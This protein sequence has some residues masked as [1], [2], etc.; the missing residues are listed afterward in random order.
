MK[1]GINLYNSRNKPVESYDALKR[2]TAQKY[3]YDDKYILASASNSMYS[4]FTHSSFE[5][6]LITGSS[7]KAVGGE[8]YI[9]ANGEIVNASSIVISGNALQAHSGNKFLKIPAGTTGLTYE[10]TIDPAYNPSSNP[11]SALNTYDKLIEEKDY[12]VYLWSHRQSTGQPDIEVYLTDAGGSNQSQLAHNATSILSTPS[13]QLFKLDFKIPHQS[14]VK[15]V[16][17]KAVNTGTGDIYV[18]DFR[19]QPTSAAVTAYVYDDFS[20]QV[21]YTLNEHNMYSKNVYD[22]AGRV[23][24]QFVETKNG[25]KLLKQYR[26][27]TPF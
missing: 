3:G 27:N 16:V 13:W 15:N 8:V 25:E 24:Q 4:E 1:G 18:D 6:E 23:L 17:I 19:V 5:D 21:T 12:S 10:E 14:S 7:R 11:S 26:Y 22:D 9:T 20:G 2:F